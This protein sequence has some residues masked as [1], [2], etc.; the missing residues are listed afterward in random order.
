[1]IEWIGARSAPHRTSVGTNPQLDT[2]DPR[3]HLQPWVP[4]LFPHRSHRRGKGWIGE[5]ANCYSAAVG[6]LVTFPVHRGAAFGTEVEIDDVPA[7]SRPTIYFTLS[8]ESDI[9]LWII[10]TRMH[11]CAGAALAGLA[12][13]DVGAKW[14]AGDDRPQGAA[15]ALCCSFHWSPLWSLYKALPL[16]STIIRYCA[17]PRIVRC[18]HHRNG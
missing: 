3:R 6:I 1:M 12:M 7:V 10:G 8:F 15:V 9:R 18:L 16:H 2:F 13:A 11:N 4:A 14:L 5:A 17:S